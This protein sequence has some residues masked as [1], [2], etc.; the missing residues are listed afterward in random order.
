M[1]KI[2]RRILNA[3]FPPMHRYAATIIYSGLT[4]PVTLEAPDDYHARQELD[5]IADGGCIIHFARL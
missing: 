4:I 5:T 3:L 2:A 1:K